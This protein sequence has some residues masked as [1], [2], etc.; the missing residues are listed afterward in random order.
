MRLLACAT[1]VTLG[2]GSTVRADIIFDPGNT[3]GGDNVLFNTASDIIGPAN[4]LRG[5][6]GNTTKQVDIVGAE[7]SPCQQLRGRSGDDCERR[8]RFYN[9]RHFLD[10]ASRRRVHPDR[11]CA[12]G[13][14]AD[15]L[16]V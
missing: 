4:I 9:S 8:W 10:N 3:P 14:P 16:N 6:I 5:H 13:R 7:K 11:V 2:I 1:L 12:I 15:Y